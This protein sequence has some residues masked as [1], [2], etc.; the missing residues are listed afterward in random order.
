MTQGPEQ[1]REIARARLGMQVKAAEKAVGGVIQAAIQNGASPESFT[2]MAVVYDPAFF[3]PFSSVALSGAYAVTD[4]GGMVIVRE[5]EIDNLRL[6]IHESAHRAHNIYRREK[7]LPLVK[8][9]IVDLLRSF[10]PTPQTDSGADTNL[11]LREREEIVRQ[12]LIE[13]G[14]DWVALKALGKDT[15]RTPEDM[16]KAGDVFYPFHTFFVAEMRRLVEEGRRN[17]FDAKLTESILTGS[18]EGLRTLVEDKRLATYLHD[19]A[20]FFTDNN[21]YIPPSQSF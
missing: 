7:K 8:D 6:V 21:L 2:H 5:E 1:T 20:S 9:L 10:P 19:T 17:E 11:D 14:A 13:G 4:L 16:V 3:I 15:N 18:F 12:I